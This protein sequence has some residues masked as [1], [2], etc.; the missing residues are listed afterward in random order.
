M[1]GI[2][3][4]N[5]RE[6]TRAQEFGEHDGIAHYEGRGWRGFHHHATLC[7]LRI[8]YLRKAIPPQPPGS[9]RSL[10]YPKVPTPRCR[11]S[12][13]NVTSKTRSRRSENSSPLHSQKPLRDVYAV[14]QCTARQLSISVHDT[15][16]LT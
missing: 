4:P 13:P 3:H 5:R 2:R 14:K 1:C 16:E 7:S 8:P 15:V 9:A 6:F 10:H 12:D 11:Q